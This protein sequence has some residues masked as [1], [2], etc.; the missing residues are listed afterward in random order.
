MF[1]C[2]V[3]GLIEYWNLTTQAYLAKEVA[4]ADLLNLVVW[5]LELAPDP[6]LRYLP[7]L[8]F[9]PISNSHTS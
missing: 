9:F 3:S 1:N 6:K 7:R 2:S 8:P 5:S 4:E